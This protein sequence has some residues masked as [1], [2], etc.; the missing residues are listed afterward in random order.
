MARK[1]NVEVTGK[2]T[3]VL[4]GLW[5]IGRG[6]WGGLPLLT[7]PGDSN[8]YLLVGGG[9]CVLIDSGQGPPAALERRMRHAGVRA[10]DVAEIWITHSHWDHFAGAALW[11]SKHP[12]CKVRIAR[13]AVQMLRRGDQRLIGGAIAGK[14]P[15]PVPRR[16][17]AVDDGDRLACPPYEFAAVA[18]P[19]HTPDCTGFRGV[20][21]GVDCLFSGDA[22]IGDQVVG[23][24]VIGW[25]DGL[26]LSD[27]PSYR[28]TL[29]KAATKP[30]GL[31]LPGHGRPIAGAAV[32]RSIR[33]CRNRLAQL[34]DIPHL[35]SMLPV[36]NG[37]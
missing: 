18:L 11:Q 27:V 34:M 14:G 15:M 22:I 36:F 28:R 24:G 13:R 23:N 21:D 17:A 19:G 3:Q 29:E 8:I 30:P 7:D 6:Q 31:L 12:R 10:S 25:L 5:W 2:P 4:G 37:R 32:A 1:P 20:V 9:R 16:L 33:N 26:W 35:Q